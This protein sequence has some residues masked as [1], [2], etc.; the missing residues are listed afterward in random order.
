MPLTDKDMEELIAQGATDEE[1]LALDK[2]GAPAPEP[3]KAPGLLE[4]TGLSALRGMVPMATVENLRRPGATGTDYASGVASD[5][6]QSAA[7]GAAVLTGGVP[8]LV[9]MLVGGA[10]VGA[11]Q[12]ALQPLAQKTGR[13]GSWVGENLTPVGWAAKAIP[14]EPQGNYAKQL[15]LGMLKQAPG[16]IGE[17][18]GEF[19]PTAAVMALGGRAIGKAAAPPEPVAPAIAA[20]EQAGG[21]IT[22]AMRAASPTGLGGKLKSGLTTAA[23]ISARSNPLLMGK[24]NKIDSANAAAAADVAKGILGQ[25]VLVPGEGR[26]ATG[27]AIQGGLQQMAEA[28]R[29]EYQPAVKALEVQKGGASIAP[30]V[31][32]GVT[33]RLAGLEIADD[34]KQ[35]FTKALAGLLQDNATPMGVDKALTSLQGR[36]EKQLGGVGSYSHD[37]QRQINW[38]FKKMMGATKDAYTEALNKKQ[39]WAGDV[40]NLEGPPE[41]QVTPKALG[42]FVREKKGDYREASQA[43]DPVSASLKHLGEAPEQVGGKLLGQGSGAIKATLAWA[44]QKAP[45]AGDVLR[46]GMARALYQE[47]GGVADTLRNMLRSKKYR[48]VV[49]L[50]G[51]EGKNLL[52]IADVADLAEGNMLERVNRSGTGKWVGAGAH[53][54]AFVTPAAWPGLLAKT[55]M[56]VGYTSGMPLLQRLSAAAREKYTRPTAQAIQSASPGAMNLALMAGASKR[57]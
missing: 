30:E 18:L 41:Q 31:E 24:Y 16:A 37:L 7:L 29:A 4:R 43:L 17:T 34:H 6:G 52:K 39:P 1:I 50:L 51:E 12:G 54:G 20:L 19:A 42:D 3:V 10:A 46:K 5:I 55:A 9:R 48:D 33:D 35:A 25:D 27:Q 53:L 32:A 57:Q 2:E 8:M 49:P 36:F 11:A 22:P 38:D 14:A 56:D 23:E 28:R 44:D 47:S 21:Q 40:V 13:L 26:P 45:G 15:A